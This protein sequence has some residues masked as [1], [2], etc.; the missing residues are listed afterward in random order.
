M[1][2]KN[3]NNKKKK[4]SK[5]KNSNKNK[6]TNNRSTA[7]VPST[8]APTPYRSPVE[9][10]DLTVSK[11][12]GIVDPFCPH[13]KGARWPD[14]NSDSTMTYQV[15]A[16]VTMTTKTQNGGTL[17]F[18]T[19]SMPYFYLPA[20]SVTVPTYTLASA[21]VTAG[22]VPFSIY[23]STYRVVTAGIIIRNVL[24][25]LTAAGILV[26][27]RMAKMPNVGNTMEEGLMYGAQITSYPIVAGMEVPVAFHPVGID[28]RDFKINNTTTTINDG[29]D[30]IKVEVIGAPVGTLT[31][32]VEV[33]VNVEFTLATGYSDLAQLAGNPANMSAPAQ[34]I[35]NKVSKAA[36]TIAFDSLKSFGSQVASMA[37]TAL[38][39]RVGGLFGGAIANRSTKALTDYVL[40][41]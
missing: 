16:L 2:K 27:T 7:M 29:W 35:A 38:G 17:Y 13:A 23:S 19:P 33:V 21:Y 41:D 24:P 36:S 1:P 31:L 5:K 30:V 18:F 9:G 11:I 14:G 26:V 40:V 28:S 39:T 3:S 12:C 34:S 15:R 6:N 25:A 32:S 37:A 22:S 4:Q 8:K 20:A 10:G